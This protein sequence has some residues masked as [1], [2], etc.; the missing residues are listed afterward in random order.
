[1]IKSIGLQDSTEFSALM[2]I[3]NTLFL[4]ND[5]ITKKYGKLTLIEWII[6]YSELSKYA[7][8]NIKTQTLILS[9]KEIFNLINNRLKSSEK[10]D[11]LIDY[12][13]FNKKKQRPI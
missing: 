4:K 5:V 3:Q 11:L 6:G 1:M 8:E 2:F 12:L 10:T 9:K 13:T 7:K